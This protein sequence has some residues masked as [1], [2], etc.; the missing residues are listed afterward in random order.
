MKKSSQLR[1]ILALCFLG[2]FL[3]C[4]ILDSDSLSPD[5]IAEVPFGE[6]NFPNLGEYWVVDK[7]GVVDQSVVEHVDK[8]LED[9]RKDGYAEQAIVTMSGVDDSIAYVTQLG[10]H[11]KLGEA[12]GEN[13]DNGII[14][15]ILVDKPVGERVRYSIGLGLPEFTS[16]EAGRVQDAASVFAD[17]GDWSN[18]VLQ[19]ATETREIFTS[20]N[21]SESYTVVEEPAN[22]E[23][24][25]EEETTKLI[26]IV[27]IVI[28]AI[29]I[30]GI[31]LTIIDPDLGEMWFYFWIRIIASVAGGGGSRRSG[32]SGRFGGRS[33]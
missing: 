27:V 24:L 16:F 7:E 31:I 18:T 25:T 17:E 11:L 4:G 20:A 15:L 1:L 32:R 28:A 23:E 5:Q 8:I 10:R 14:W 9:L 26:I 3:S 30:I 22:E 29:V 2:I 12:E 6:P 19:I 21:D 33:C 13:K